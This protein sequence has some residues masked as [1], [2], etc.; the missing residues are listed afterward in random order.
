[1]TEDNLDKGQPFTENRSLILPV[2]GLLGAQWPS[3]PEGSPPHARQ[4]S[5]DI[6]LGEESKVI[7]AALP[8]RS[9]PT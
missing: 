7:E 9:M 6:E 8:A 5:E 2:P 3:S 1:M 4:N